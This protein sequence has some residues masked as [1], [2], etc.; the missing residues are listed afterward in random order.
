MIIDLEI[1]QFIKE[2]KQ[3]ADTLEGVHKDNALKKVSLLNR[4]QDELKQQRQFAD[5]AIH[6]SQES[7]IAELKMINDY[8]SLQ[9]EN[10]SLK[11]ELDK[12]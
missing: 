1:D 7:S 4:I 6:A 9:L 12:F 11:K 2:I 10:E 3:K 5:N 8:R